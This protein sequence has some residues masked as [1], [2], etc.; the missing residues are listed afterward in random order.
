MDCYFSGYYDTEAHVIAKEE[1]SEF[2]VAIES[3]LCYATVWSFGCTTNF[4]G[5]KK[6]D[7]KMRELL[8]GY[9]GLPPRDGLVHDF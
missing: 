6:F 1:I 7:S 8:H 3:L 5:R 4:E 9:I 2:E